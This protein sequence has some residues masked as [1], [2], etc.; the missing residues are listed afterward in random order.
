M[1]NAEWRVWEHVSESKRRCTAKDE[2]RNNDLK[3][4]VLGVKHTS[5]LKV[6]FWGERRFFEKTKMGIIHSHLNVFM[7]T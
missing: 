3:P 2:C 5:C 4:V 6:Q 7:L 1:L